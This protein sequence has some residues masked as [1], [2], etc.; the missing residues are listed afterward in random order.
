VRGHARENALAKNSQWVSERKGIEA[1]RRPGTNEL[2][3]EDDEGRL[4]EGSQTNFFAVIDG[5]VHTAGE[6]APC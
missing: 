5:C 4:V 2:L 1:A 6:G 3:L